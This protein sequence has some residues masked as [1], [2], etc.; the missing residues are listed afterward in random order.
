MLQVLFNNGNIENYDVEG[1]IR[2]GL[3]SLNFTG[4]GRMIILEYSH[5]NYFLI[6]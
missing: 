2:F 6:L 5:I 4:N 1:K 3:E